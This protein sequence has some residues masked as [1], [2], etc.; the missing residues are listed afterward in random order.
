MFDLGRKAEKSG[1]IVEAYLM[2]SQAAAAEPKNKLFWGK[3]EALRTR[4]A[5]LANT[6]PADLSAPA[7]A[8]AAADVPESADVEESPAADVTPPTAKELDDARKPQA[9]ATLAGS[10]DIKSFHLTADSKELFEQ[11]AKA[12]GLDVVFDG[13]YTPTPN[14]PF[15]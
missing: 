2:Y 3:A 7:D 11:V 4:A 12:Y 6:M 1:R 10:P 8:N 15:H 14:V 5:M 9:P 13:D